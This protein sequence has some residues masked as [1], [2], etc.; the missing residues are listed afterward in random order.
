[1]RASN[2]CQMHVQGDR[3]K[4]PLGHDGPLA[5]KPDPVHEGN[6]LKF[7]QTPQGPMVEEL[8]PRTS[9]RRNRQVNRFIRELDHHERT[10]GPKPL[11]FFLDMAL[12]YLRRGK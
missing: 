11:A 3:C 8:H 4:K 5:L 10:M 9:P 6:N 1:M 2:R 12:K 7:Y